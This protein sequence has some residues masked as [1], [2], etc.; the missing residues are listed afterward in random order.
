MK[1]GKSIVEL[2]T[3]I[4]RQA[5]AKVDYLADTRKM[6][7]ATAENE[8]VKLMV[9]N[10]DNSVVQLS[11]NNLAHRQIAERVGIP[12]KYYDRMLQEDPA[13]L[14]QNVN[15]W[16][17]RD[18]EQRMVRTL[19]GTARA[20]L[21]NRYQ[22]IDN[23]HVAEAVLPVL[24]GTKGVEI[25]P[26]EITDSRLYIKAVTHSIRA[27]IQS[28]RHAANKGDIVEAGVIIS[29]SEVGLGSVS[30]S[31][32]FNFLWCTNGM[33]RAKE[34]VRSN[35]VGTK[36]DADDYISGILADDTRKAMDRSVLLK[37]RD[38][39][40]AAMSQV[41]FDKAVAEMNAA[42]TQQITGSPI[43]AVETLANDF[44]FTDGERDSVLRH[45][46]EGGDL[47][48]YGFMNA[49]TR[50]AEDMPSYDRAI[51][52]EAAGGRVLDLAAK[53]WNRIAVAA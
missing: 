5:R 40:A 27:E 9:H 29:N 28:K 24:M 30:I 46:I 35:H 2:A 25:M 48:R 53:D 44:G 39:V 13:L 26:S 7:L 15:R 47:S 51:E 42:A 49:V 41:Q 19:D 10:A 12:A 21:S 18:P 45:L 52:F 20:F 34:G 50:A 22:R 14:A 33:I 37:V 32:F 43:A 23:Q 36:M 17:E 3:E 4:E 31:P 6:E 16:F 8:P 1:S 38:V 11:I